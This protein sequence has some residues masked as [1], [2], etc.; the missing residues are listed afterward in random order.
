MATVHSLD[1][2][3]SNEF[4]RVEDD[5]NGA[6][7]RMGHTAIF[8]RRTELVYVFGGSKNKKWY[9]DINI[10][11]SKTKKWVTVEVSLTSLTMRAWYF[12]S[13]L[14]NAVSAITNDESKVNWY[15]PARISKIQT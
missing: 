8:D 15:S 11:N 9:S 13:S 4:E 7:R 10:L 3:E 1:P 14:P 12:N 2:T 5:S 6:S